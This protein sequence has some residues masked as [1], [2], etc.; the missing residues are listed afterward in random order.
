MVDLLKFFCPTGKYSVPVGVTYQD[1]VEAIYQVE[2]DTAAQVFYQ[3]K[4][5]IN[6]G[7]EFQQHGYTDRA[8]L[9]FYDN[10]RKNGVPFAQRDRLTERG[11]VWVDRHGDVGHVTERRPYVL[12]VDPN[13]GELISIS[14]GPIV[15]Y[16]KLVALHRNWR[17]AFGVVVDEVIELHWYLD[18]ACTQR[19]EVYRYGWSKQHGGLGL[20]EFG[21]NEGLNARLNGIWHAAPPAANVPVLERKPNPV[22]K[23][24]ITITPATPVVTPTLPP[25][26]TVVAKLVRADI[27]AGAKV[28][29]GPT[30][31]APTL[32]T[33]PALAPV[34]VIGFADS[35]DGDGYQWAQ[36]REGGY[37]RDDLLGLPGAAT[38]GATIAKFSPPVV[39]LYTITSRH[40]PDKT[41]P[42]PHDGVDLAAAMETQ[43]AARGVGKV[44]FLYRCAYCTETKPTW[45]A[46]GLTQAQ[47]TAAFNDPKWGYGYGDSVIVRFAYGDLPDA[48]RAELDRLGLRGGF[49]YVIHAH[50][51]Q[52][53]VDEGDCVGPDTVIGTMGQDG[54]SSGPH[55][56]VECRVSLKGDETS[57]YNR[58]QIDP[59]LIYT[60]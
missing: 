53:L 37:V 34:Q 42:K 57:I 59:G 21:D 33:L 14:E 47:R 45:D 58:T 31:S 35:L 22:D 12:D 46:H 54:N 19:A 39:G 9:F 55:L 48:A 2:H 51:D 52:I 16:M 7:C 6:A 28:R 60:L 18:K 36:R 5:H 10:S 32:T 40:Q 11:A 15:T 56:H 44:A 29:Q 38:P 25:A 23:L 3:N 41:R 20:I 50:L 1:G 26:P 17:S 24:R 43:V 8:I 27:T 49:A 4:G 13:T 30:T